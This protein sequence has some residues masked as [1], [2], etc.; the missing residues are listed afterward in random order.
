MDIQAKELE[1]LKTEQRE[2]AI[3]SESERSFY[4]VLIVAGI[5]ILVLVVVF[6][7]VRPRENKKLR[8]G[9]NLHTIKLK[10]R[11][12]HVRDQHS[13]CQTDTASDSS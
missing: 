4:Q 2:A 9:C 10:P 1:K 5:V 3:K 12:K 8:T 13:L 6:F 11:T 7:L